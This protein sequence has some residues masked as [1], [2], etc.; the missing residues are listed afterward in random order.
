[1]LC[2]AASAFLLYFVDPF[3]GVCFVFGTAVFLIFHS[4]FLKHFK[5]EGTCKIYLC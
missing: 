3:E 1:M 5:V 4:N 2:Q